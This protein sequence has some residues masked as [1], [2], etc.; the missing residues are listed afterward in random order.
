M[1][2]MPNVTD[3]CES[4]PCWLIEDVVNRGLY[5][6]RGSRHVVAALRQLGAS[7]M[8]CEIWHVEFTDWFISQYGEGRI[9]GIPG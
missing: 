9:F 6:R 3:P 1:L 4:T 2:V 5:H 8:R 7:V